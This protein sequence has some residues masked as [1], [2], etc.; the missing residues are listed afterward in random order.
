MTAMKQGRPLGS[1]IRQ[2]IIDILFFL[3]RAHGY[4][5]YKVY[6][7]IFPK[8]TLRVVYYN[9]KKGVSLDE[10]KILKIQEKKGDYSWG[11]R[12]QRIYYSLGKNASPKL[13]ERVKKY[14]DKLLE[15]EKQRNEET[16]KAKSTNI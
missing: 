13:D 4:K 6:R 8:V 16:Q 15:K 12:A 1:I 7:K 3:R 10:F 5:I 11:D 2:N 14:F 9:L